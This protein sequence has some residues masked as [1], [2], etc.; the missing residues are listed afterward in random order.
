MV[1]EKLVNLEEN[2]QFQ[3]LVLHTKHWYNAVER[4]DWINVI[5]GTVSWFV[6][7]F[8]WGSGT[9]WVLDWGFEPYEATSQV[10][11]LVVAI[12]NLKKMTNLEWEAEAEN[13]VVLE[14]VDIMAMEIVDFEKSLWLLL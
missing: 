5:E 3:C 12:K 9:I 10:A 1:V 8:D 13:T 7:V 6:S 14:L 2:V 4:C 11:Y